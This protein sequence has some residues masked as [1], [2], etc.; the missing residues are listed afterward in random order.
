MM[1]KI[2]ELGSS[3]RD[4][5]RLTKLVMSAERNKR[6]THTER[7]REREREREKERERF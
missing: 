7:E 6:A 3:S 5:F 2:E 4:A 1:T